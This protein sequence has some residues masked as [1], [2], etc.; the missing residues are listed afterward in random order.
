ME[1]AMTTLRYTC[2]EAQRQMTAFALACLAALKP[3]W[4][5]T[6]EDDA[7]N[8]IFRQ[9]NLLLKEGKIVWGAL[10]QANALLFKPGNEDCPALLVYSTDAY[11]DSRPLE[12]QLIAHKI[13]SFKE[14]NPGDP[15]LKEVARLVTDEMD[16]SMGFTLPRVFSDKEIRWAAFMVFRQHIPRGVLSSGLFPLLIHPSTQAVMIVPSKFWPIELLAMWK[17]DA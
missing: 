8:E 7:L 1:R 16:R 11:F 3:P 10:V 2:E 6:R 4:L 13:G 14:T 5:K 12:L 17:K 15:E 9:Q